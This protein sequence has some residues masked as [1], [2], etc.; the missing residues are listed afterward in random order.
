MNDWDLSPGQRQLAY[1]DLKGMAEAFTALASLCGQPDVTISERDLLQRELE[2]R[3]C[4]DCPRHVCCFGRA[5]IPTDV[6][7]FYYDILKKYGTIYAEDITEDIR[8][9]CPQSRRLAATANTAYEIILSR[10]GEMRA[11]RRTRELLTAQYGVMSRAL[12]IT[13]SRIR[14]TARNS[15]VEDKLVS[16][17]RGIGLRDFTVLCMEDDVGTQMVELTMRGAGFN[18]EIAI[19]VQRVCSLCCNSAMVA[20]YDGYGFETSG[21]NRLRL[22]PA[23]KFTVEVGT[24]LRSKEDVCG[25]STILAVNRY[26]HGIFGIADG[27]GTGTD[28]ANVSRTVSA[29]CERAF[30]MGMPIEDIVMAANGA[31]AILT[32]N[33]KYTTLDLLD[34][35]MQSGRAQIHKL[36]GCPTLLM[37]RGHIEQLSGTGKPLGMMDQREEVET[38]LLHHGDTLM[39]CSDG[40]WNNLP[41]DKESAIGDIMNMP[42]LTQAADII[43]GMCQIAVGSG[44]GASDDMTVLLVRIWEI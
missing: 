19:Q 17:L 36:C 42:D 35:D 30:A 15:M 40:I 23:N 16:K 18:K 12:M 28:A 7:G 24:S 13:A 34:V 38:T 4:A 1:A 21:S 32:D 33:N 44:E 39:M 2:R 8:M 25:D 29:M 22:I 31:T 41:E 20:D 5:E 37:R 26:G 43:A 11:R 9:I 14:G 27:M 3:V 10:L 6:F